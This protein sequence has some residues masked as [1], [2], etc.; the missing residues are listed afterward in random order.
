MKGMAAKDSLDT[1]DKA[2]K[3]TFPQ[4]RL[5]RVRGTAW[6][7]TAA[8]AEQRGN[9]YPIASNQ[10]ERDCPHRRLPNFPSSCLISLYTSAAVGA[11]SAG[12][13]WTMTA[14][15]SLTSP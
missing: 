5:F 6:I 7:K 8:A 11:S 2:R 1:E 13:D 14:T 3:K 12:L 10:K 15:P 9:P 4:N